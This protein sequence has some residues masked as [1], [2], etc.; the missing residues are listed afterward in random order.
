MNDADMPDHQTSITLSG[1]AATARL[2]VSLAPRLRAGDVVLIEGPIGAGKSH[3][4]RSLIQHLLATEGRSEDV[5]SPTYTLVQVYELEGVEI[6]HA[7]LY[8]LTTP[9][10]VFELGLDEAFERSICLVEWPDRLGD[11][12]PADALTLRLV[13][14]DDPE[15]RTAILSARSARWVPVIAGLAAPGPQCA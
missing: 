14:A 7:D 5:P 2:A 6:W 9:D 1:A 3:F 15:T 11:T 8:R 10:D 4:C 13:Q 12:S